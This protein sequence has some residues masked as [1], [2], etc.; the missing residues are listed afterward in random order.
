M[1]AAGIVSVE[2]VLV[3]LEVVDE[4]TDFGG[5][6]VGV[7]K[8]QLG[9]HRRVEACDASEVLVGSRGEPMSAFRSAASV[10]KSSA[11]KLS[12]KMYI[13]G[14]LEIALAMARR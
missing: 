7:V 14:L 4:H 1:E 9:P 12:S 5:E 13:S 2:G 8:E 6:V 10:L 11:E 3:L